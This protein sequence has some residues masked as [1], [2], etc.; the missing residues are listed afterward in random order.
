MFLLAE[1]IV[2]DAEEENRKVDDKS[3]GI[4]NFNG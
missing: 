4:A 3:K 1:D 2:P